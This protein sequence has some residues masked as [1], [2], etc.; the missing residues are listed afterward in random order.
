MEIVV[1]GNKPFLRQKDE[2]FMNIQNL[3]DAKRKM[4]L[5]KQHKIQNISKQNEFLIDVKEDYNKHYIYI[6]Q[7]KQDQ[8]RALELLDQYIRDLTTSG[9]LSVNN[10]EDAKHEQRKIMREIN[11]IKKGLDGIMS[12]LNETSEALK[13]NT[14]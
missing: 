1:Y 13:A 10:I 8:V 2:Q 6:K 7:Q 9:S 4:L 14:I 11:S 3:I 5:D 12:G